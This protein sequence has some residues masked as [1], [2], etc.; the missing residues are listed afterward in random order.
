MKHFVFNSQ[1]EFGASMNA[2]SEDQIKNEPMF[3]SCNREFVM[4]HGGPLSINFLNNLSNE[5]ENANDL[6]I[7]SRVHMLMKGWFP[8]I[9]GYHH[10]DVPRG[11]NGQPYYNNPSYLAKHCM[12]LQNG[13][14]A[15]TEF[16]LGESVFPDVEEGQ[17][18]YKI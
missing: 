14:I 17:T 16:A 2:F 6:I 4:K 1:L 13:K 18:Y 3:F 5:F 7:D 10:D 9:P 15:P 11:A 8:C 12:A